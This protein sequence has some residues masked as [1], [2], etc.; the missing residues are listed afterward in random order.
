VDVLAAG[1]HSRVRSQA[2]G[3]HH[4]SALPLI[5]GIDAVVRDPKGRIRYPVLEDTTLGTMAGRTVIELAKN[6]STKRGREVIQLDLSYPAS[7]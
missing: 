1:L 6:R 5:P 4:T 3:S 7:P 2:N